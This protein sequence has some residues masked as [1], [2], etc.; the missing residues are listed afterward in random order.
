[1]RGIS[2]SALQKI[3]ELIDDHFESISFNFLGLVPKLKSSR[4]VFDANPDS[5]VSLFINALGD[6][7]PTKTEEDTLKSLL[8]VADSYIDALKERTKAKV[9][10]DINGYVSDQ[11]KSG[12]AINLRVVSDILDKNLDKSKT[13]FQVIA[14]SESKTVKNVATALKIVKVNENMGINR[15]VVFYNV[16]L[17][18]KTAEEPEKNIHLITG[19]S[20]PRLWYLDELSN[21]YWQKGMEV[22]SIHGGHPNCF[23]G[24]QGL[25]V[26]EEKKGYVNIKEIEI[27][28]RVLTHTGKFKRVLNTLKW[29]NKKYYKNYV[30]IKVKTTHTDG[31][32]ISTFKITPEHQFLTNK[33]WVEAQNITTDHKLQKLKVPCA[34]C[35]KTVN[36]KPA[37]KL[38]KNRKS[39]I[40]SKSFCSFSCSANY[41]WSQDGHRENISIKNS[42]YMKE[43]L[44]ENPHFCSERIK[45]AQKK[46]KELQASGQFW[47]QKPEN[48]EILQINMAKINKVLQSKKSSKEEDTVYKIISK[49]FPTVRRQELLYRWC[50]DFYI[51]ELKVNIEYDGGGHYLPVYTKSETMDSF[52]GKQKGRDSYLQKCGIHVLRYSHIPTEEEIKE[53][54]VRVSNNS[55]NNYFFE[56]EEIISIKH[57]KGSKKGYYLY[58]L[59]V[60]D[61]ESFVVNGIVSH[62]CRCILQTLAPGWGF[63]D[64]GKVKWISEDYNAIED[65]RNKYLAPKSKAKKA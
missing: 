18:L 42:T 12:K 22:P 27:G 23:L 53:D 31:D 49:I 13:Q 45:K 4:I 50:V 8:F 63:D 14:N 59:T 32:K 55:M 5:L 51:P 16:T 21:E 39:K 26:F 2:F 19:T 25:N 6:G 56:D 47:A 29:Y 10:H 60:E 28:D 30:V 44:K 40:G 33:G 20:I 62:N 3:A 36:V 41:Q 15:P 46:T 35:G 1:M 38:S 9:L 24:H 11:K 43:K 61:D 7:E 57:V 17:D 37:R 58:D 54:V 64:N 52:M 65:Q 34:N 48:I